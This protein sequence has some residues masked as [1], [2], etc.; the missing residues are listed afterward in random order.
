MTRVARGRSVA[1]ESACGRRMGAVEG[2]VVAIRL[3]FRSRDARGRGV[4]VGRRARVVRASVGSRDDAG[5][6]GATF[7]RGE[8][9]G[10]RAR[11]RASGVERAA[12]RRARVCA[13]AK[14]DVVLFRSNE[15]GL[16]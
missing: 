9:G 11:R 8:W 13:A 5:R 4:V 6:L 14:R 10:F 7:A 15:L 2:D 16:T 12:S 3:G 1:R